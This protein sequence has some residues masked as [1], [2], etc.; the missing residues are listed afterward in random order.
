[1][2]TAQLPGAFDQLWGE[3]YATAASVGIEQERLLREAVLGRAGEDGFLRIGVF[4]MYITSDVTIAR[5][6]SSA[7]IEQSGGGAYASFST[8]GFRLIGS[9]GLA[10]PL[11]MWPDW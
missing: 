7:E 11:A 5:L 2:P 10:S 1:M 3:V 4:G 8:G 9:A 6:G